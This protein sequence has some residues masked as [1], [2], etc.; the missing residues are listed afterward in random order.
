M[1]K[2]SIIAVIVLVVAAA[3]LMALHNPIG[4]A[5][6]RAGHGAPQPSQSPA[7]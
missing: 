2:R 4:R 3:A 6:G 5:L 7:R 1:S